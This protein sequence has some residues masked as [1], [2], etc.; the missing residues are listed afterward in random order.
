MEPV[1]LGLGERL[2][3]VLPTVN[4][5]LNSL[6]AVL[7]FCGWLAIRRREVTIHRRCMI[8]AFS[9]SALFLVSYLVRFAL[10]GTHRYGG[11]G[12]LK[13]VYLVLLFSHMALAAAVPV[14]AIA[15]LWLGLKGRFD[16]HRRWVRWAYPIW[17]YVSV[18]GVI[19]YLMLYHGPR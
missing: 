15:S 17:M 12:A 5:A 10:T 19:V 16:R 2:G 11:S 13:V 1:T 4:A 6:S 3:A 18:T 8:G 14:L 7:L 9:V